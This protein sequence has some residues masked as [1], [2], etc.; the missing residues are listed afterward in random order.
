MLSKSDAWQ[1]PQ[2]SDLTYQYLMMQLSSVLNDSYPTC[3]LIVFSNRNLGAD[4]FSKLLDMAY[5]AD[6]LS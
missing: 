1:L 3:C 5:Y 4:S 6:F 2:I